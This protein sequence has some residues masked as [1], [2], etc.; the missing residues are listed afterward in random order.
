MRPSL[1]P[2]ARYKL[3]RLEHVTHVQQHPWGDSTPPDRDA[4]AVYELGTQLLEEVERLECEVAR[5]E[6]ALVAASEPDLLKRGCR[7]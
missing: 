7:R 5:L 4:V 6:L 1:V 3:G 2:D